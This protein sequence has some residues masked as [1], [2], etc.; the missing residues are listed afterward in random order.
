MKAPLLAALASFFLLLTC[1]MLCSARTPFEVGCE[2]RLD[3][4][5]LNVHTAE[6]GYAV[7][8][9]RSFKTL[10]AMRGSGQPGQYVLGLTHT[11][12]R[13]AIALAADMLVD[14]AAGVECLSPRIDVSIAYVPIVIYVGH[15]FVPGSC[16]YQA[17]LA[18]EMRHLNA[19][20]EYLPKVEQV[21]R[22]KFNGRLGGRVQFAQVGQAQARLQ[23]ELDQQW[24]P[25]I[26]AEVGKAESLQRAIDSPKEY[27]RLSKVCAGEVQSLIGRRRRAEQQND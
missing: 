3:K 20:L 2:Q 5:S 12:S 25:F 6:A 1:P 26:K 17:I 23:G 8:T 7:D 18:H 13:I 19:Y 21:V 16:A 24:L 10:T 4:P 15:E 22:N 9:S 14:R 27:A 11:E